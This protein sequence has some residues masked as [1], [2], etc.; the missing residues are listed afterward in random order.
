MAR[1]DP[2]VFDAPGG[3]ARIRLDARGGGTF[4]AVVQGDRMRLEPASG[5]RAD[6]LLG[7]DVGTWASMAEDYQGGMDAYSTGAL[8]VRRNLHLAIGFLTATSGST[9]PGRLKMGRVET[10]MGSLATLEAGTGDPLVML[11]GLGA[12][13]ASFVPT[14]A[15]LASEE[16]RMIAVDLPGFGDSVKPLGA[17]YH[18]PFFARSVVGL[19]DAL[20]LDRPDVLGHS[21]GGRVAIDMGIRHPDRVARLVLMTPALAWRRSRRWAPWVKLLR[22]ELGLIQPTNRRAVEAVVRRLVPGAEN[23]W[24]AAA[25][26]EF[27]RSFLTPR[28]RAAF[29]AAARQIYLEEPDGPR[30]FWARLAEMSPDALFIWGKRDTLVPIGFARHVEGVLPAAKH[31]ELACGH[32]PQLERPKELHA[33]IEKFLRGRAKPV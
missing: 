22:P 2:S 5:D 32:V 31:V 3:S 19:L 26:D 30:G 29:Y 18:A 17:R 14:I 1:F 25:V 7:A 13:K 21:M 10:P 6:A 24:V 33:A 23:A 4:D 20:E 27:L 15:A 8:L 9:E 11:H 28:G 12:T 16:R